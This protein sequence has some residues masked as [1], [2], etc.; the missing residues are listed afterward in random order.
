MSYIILEIIL[1]IVFLCEN[2]TVRFGKPD[3]PVFPENS[4]IYLFD[5]ILLQ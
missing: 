3:D 2:R 1:S 5:L 4:Y